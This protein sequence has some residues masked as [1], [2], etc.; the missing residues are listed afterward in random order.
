MR[1]FAWTTQLWRNIAAV[2]TGEWL[3]SLCPIWPAREL[4]PKPPV[5]IA[6]SL[7]IALIGSCAIKYLQFYGKIYSFKQLLRCVGMV[8]NLLKWVWTAWILHSAIKQRKDI[9][10]CL[11]LSELST[12]AP[13]V[14]SWKFAHTLGTAHLAHF[15]A[16][17]TAAFFSSS[18]NFSKYL[19][20]NML[21]WVLIACFAL[22]TGE[23]ARSNR[24]I[25]SSLTQVIRNERLKKINLVVHNGHDCLN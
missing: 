21:S 16:N 14:H 24:K 1:G 25:R 19:R 23:F 13:L 18:S 20:Y 5:P 15:V 9:L 2:A 4:N 3:A 8:S 12:S 6:M 11:F 7:T 22:A 17:K 10:F